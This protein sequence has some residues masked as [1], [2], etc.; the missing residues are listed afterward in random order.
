VRRVHGHRAVALVPVPAGEPSAQ[1]PAEALRLAALTADRARARTAG[2]D[3]LSALEAWRALLDGKWSLV[4][5]FDSNRRRVLV[6]RRNPAHGANVP[7]VSPREREIL[8]RRARLQSVKVIAYDLG[9]SQATVSRELS[10]GMRKLG[11][12]QGADLVA[13]VGLVEASP[14]P[15]PRQSRAG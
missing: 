7:L 9:I 6:A 14:E 13:F 8:G 12:E 1:S 2:E 15:A 5:S 3:A 4:D 10:S 11:I